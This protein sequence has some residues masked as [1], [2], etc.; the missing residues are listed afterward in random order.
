MV[1]LTHLNLQKYYGI[2]LNNI[3]RF[4]NILLKFSLLITSLALNVYISHTRLF[5]VKIY[6]YFTNFQRLH[7]HLPT[8]VNIHYLPHFT[9]QL[10]LNQELIRLD[11][12]E[13]LFTITLPRV[14]IYKT[15]FKLSIAKQATITKAF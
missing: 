7:S 1:Y 5:L 3:S 8:T 4:N 11:I 14:N 15:I 10:L 13:F 12:L 9:F 6:I 2:L